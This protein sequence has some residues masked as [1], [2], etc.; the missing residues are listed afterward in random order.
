MPNRKL[1]IVLGLQ[2]HLPLDQRQSWDQA[3]TTWWINIRPEG[4][5][6]L[7]RHGYNML[8]GVLGLESWE[9]ELG[10]KDGNAMTKRL[11][12]ALDQKMQWP[13]YLDIDARKKRRRIIFFGSRE[14][15]MAT[16]YGDLQRWLTN[17]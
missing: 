5:M 6:R 7:T 17:Q 3:M 13:Y 1:D 11:I 4:G 10:D 16:M 8:H 15:M 14:A 9:M 12:L 2:E